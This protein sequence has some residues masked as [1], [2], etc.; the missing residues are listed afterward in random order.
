MIYAIIN[1]IYDFIMSFFETPVAGIFSEPIQLK[2][3]RLKVPNY[4]ESSRYRGNLCNRN[5]GIL[6]KIGKKY[7]GARPL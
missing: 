3:V 2:L 4:V 5:S 6:Y 7:N 1:Y